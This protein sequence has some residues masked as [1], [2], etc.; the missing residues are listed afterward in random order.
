MNARL[1]F[2]ASRA[3]LATTTDRRARP[4]ANGAPAG[5]AENPRG[6]R[7]QRRDRARAAAVAA[8]A[9]PQGSVSDG[10]HSGRWR[11]RAARC[12]FALGSDVAARGR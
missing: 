10:A 4:R 1:T 2:L 12:T 11:G 7:F 6:P 3:E 9:I 5:R 8:K